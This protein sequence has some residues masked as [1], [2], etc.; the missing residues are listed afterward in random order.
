MK[1]SEIILGQA[2]RLRTTDWVAFAGNSVS[3]AEWEAAHP[4]ERNKLPYVIRAMLDY[5]DEREATATGDKQA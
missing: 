2:K 4:V 1:P 5:L 3:D